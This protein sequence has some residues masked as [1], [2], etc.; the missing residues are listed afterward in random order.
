MS[1]CSSG[2]APPAMDFPEVLK[3]LLEYSLPGTGNLA[4]YLISEGQGKSHKTASHHCLMQYQICDTQTAC[5][6]RDP[7]SNFPQTPTCT[8]D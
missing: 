8:S 6:R 3:S 4:E 2:G 5:S 1:G 7:T